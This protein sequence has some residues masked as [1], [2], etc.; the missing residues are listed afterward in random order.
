MI[1]TLQHTADISDTFSA[2]SYKQGPKNFSQWIR[3]QKFFLKNSELCKAQ[4]S[5]SIYFMVQ[6]RSSSLCILN[7]LF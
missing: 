5:S 6:N 4:V 3:I 1:T 7:F 2:Q